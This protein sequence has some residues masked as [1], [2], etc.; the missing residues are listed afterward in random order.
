MRRF[1]RPGDAKQYLQRLPFSTQFI[2]TLE[3]LRGRKRL[4][5]SQ[6]VGHEG[7]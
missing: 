3:D 2:K 1:A 5:R 4:D 6:R 7:S